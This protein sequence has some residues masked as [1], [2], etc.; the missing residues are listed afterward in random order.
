MNRHE[1]IDLAY[2]ERIAWLEIVGMTLAYGAY[3]VAVVAIG[4]STIPMLL[5]LFAA[6]LYFVWW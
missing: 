4:A 6:R 2:H 5:G 3:F 1:E